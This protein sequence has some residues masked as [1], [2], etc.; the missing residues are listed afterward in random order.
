M[1]DTPAGWH[2]HPNGGGLVQD[3]AYVEDSAWVY[4]NAQVYGEARVYG[5]AWKASPLF[6]EYKAYIDLFV[7]IGK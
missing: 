5:D 6:A 2:R 1:T 7:K 4:G 3:T